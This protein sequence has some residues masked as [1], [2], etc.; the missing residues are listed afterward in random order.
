VSTIDA[1]IFAAQ[2]TGRAMVFGG[3]E[4]GSAM[5]ATSLAVVFAIL[6]IVIMAYY[7]WREERKSAYNS[8]K[9]TMESTME[10]TTSLGLRGLKR[11]GKYDASNVGQL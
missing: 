1:G 11:A 6:A 10:S 3:N 5:S 2:Y 4:D 7:Y 8:A 9:S